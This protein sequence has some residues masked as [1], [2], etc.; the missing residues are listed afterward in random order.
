MAAA[1]GAVRALLV[2][3]ESDSDFARAVALLKARIQSR[4]QLW[5]N[6]DELCSEFIRV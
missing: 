1:V 6:F 2:A 4:L 3:N 5:G